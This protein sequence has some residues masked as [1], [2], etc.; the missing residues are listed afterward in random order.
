M[1]LETGCLGRWVA[2]WKPCHVAVTASDCNLP[3]RISKN[4][5]YD[6]AKHFSE[7]FSE[8]PASKGSYDSA[9]DSKKEGFRESEKLEKDVA[10][11]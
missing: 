10:G 3:Q 4:P 8:H 6:N 1:Y 2:L 9:R 5:S 11:D 7:H